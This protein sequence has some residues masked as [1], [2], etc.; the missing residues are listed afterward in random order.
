MKFQGVVLPVYYCVDEPN[1]RNGLCTTTDPKRSKSAGNPSPREI[2]RL[3]HSESF[4]VRLT[5]FRQVTVRNETW[6]FLNPLHLTGYHRVTT[7][8]LCLKLVACTELF[9]GLVFHLS[10]PLTTFAMFLKKLIRYCEFD[11]PRKKQN[12]HKSIGSGK[13][14]RK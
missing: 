12:V 3:T 9:Y 13:W 7:F 14:R 10:I 4:I 5:Y 11:W 1:P 2:L 8:L 6:P